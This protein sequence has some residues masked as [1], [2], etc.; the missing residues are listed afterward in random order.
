MYFY[1][2]FERKNTQL[3]DMSKHVMAKNGKL[4][5]EIKRL[6]TLVKE[7]EAKVKN[8]LKKVFST[9]SYYIRRNIYSIF[10]VSFVVLQ[11]H[12]ITF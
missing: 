5:A 2:Q 1:L 11:N 12:I 6:K 3:Q 7:L 9:G 8:M 10:V 4:K